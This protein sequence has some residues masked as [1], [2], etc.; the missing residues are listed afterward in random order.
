M[1]QFIF[2]PNP[3]NPKTNRKDV[4]DSLM[5]NSSLMTIVDPRPENIEV[6]QPFLDSGEGLLDVFLQTQWWVFW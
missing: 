6:Y 4:E 3:R 5:T 2:S 1:T